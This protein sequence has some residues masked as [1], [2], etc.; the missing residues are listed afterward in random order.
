MNSTKSVEPWKLGADRKIWA[1]AGPAI[2]AN[3][4]APLVGLVDTWMVG[5]LPSSIHLA[6]IGVGAT[7]FSYVF[8]TFGFLRMGTTGF[9][10]QSHGRRDSAGLAQL[11]VRVTLTSLVIAVALIL[12]QGLLFKAAVQ[13]IEPPK[14]VLAPLSDYFNIRIWAAPATLFFYG[15]NGFLIGTA[16]AKTALW[17]HLILNISNGVLNLVFVLGFDMGV[18]GIALGTLIAEWLTAIVGAVILTRCLGSSLIL[19][20]IR[21]RSTWAMRQIFALLKVNGLLLCRTLLLITAL[22]MI[23]REASQM[24]T[25]EV[26]ASQIANVFL[27]LIAL[28]LDGF[29]YAGEALAGAAWGAGNKAEFRFQVLRTS[30]WAAIASLIYAVIFYLGGDMIIASL[31]NLDDVRAVAQHIIPVMVLIPLIAFPCYQFD[32]IFIGATAAGLM[33]STMLISVVIYVIILSPLS[34][35]YGITGLW[36]A[37]AIFMGLRGLFQLICYPWLERRLPESKAL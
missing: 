20:S 32:G 2:I 12:I 19:K 35:A 8:W 34:N 1:I 28:G 7:I 33:L 21:D 3:S 27:M 23:M 29:A 9:A 16:R 37:V 10:A 31:T 18:A 15:V 5:H 14:I 13:V 36:L 26:A 25:A 17:L 4:S 24:G 30:F 11:M 6:A 22:A